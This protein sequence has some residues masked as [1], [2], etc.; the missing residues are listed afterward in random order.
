MPRR[1]RS[2]RNPLAARSIVTPS[3]ETRIVPRSPGLAAG[4]IA[5]HLR[6]FATSEDLLAARIGPFRW[7][8]V[9]GECWSYLHSCRAVA[10]RGRGFRVT[11]I[12]PPQ[13]PAV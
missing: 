6:D 9:T 12:G 7:A 10:L 11:P 2:S 8:R 5:G 1:G 13:N 4:I 3:R